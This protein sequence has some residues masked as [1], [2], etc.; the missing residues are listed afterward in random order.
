MEECPLCKVKGKLVNNKFKGK[1]V[2]NKFKEIRACQNDKC[3]I[4]QYEVINMTKYIEIPSQLL[5]PINHESLKF[6]NQYVSPQFD[7]NYSTN[8]N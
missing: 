8:N 3:T 6:N 2:N 7:M 5:P 4:L 1:L